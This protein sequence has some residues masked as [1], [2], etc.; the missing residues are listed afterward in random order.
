[1]AKA[2]ASEV[3][4]RL[5][6]G[7]MEVFATP[8]IPPGDRVEITGLPDEHPAAA[9]LGDAAAPRKGCASPARPPTGRTHP[10]ELLGAERP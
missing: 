6:R 2:W 8:A 9:L 10:S 4:A 3:A 5:L 1:V 7:S